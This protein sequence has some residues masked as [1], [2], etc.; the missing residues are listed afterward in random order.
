MRH[1]GGIIRRPAAPYSTHSRNNAMRFLILFLAAGLSLAAYPVAAQTAGTLSGTITDTAGAPVPGA[2]IVLMGTNRGALSKPDGSYLMVRVPPGT[3]QVRVTGIAMEEAR[4]EVTIAADSTA[5]L[6]FTLQPRK[7]GS[8][9]VTVTSG[10]PPEP[11]RRPDLRREDVGT[12]TGPCGIYGIPA[13]F[14]ADS[15]AKGEIAGRVIDERGNG[16]ADAQIEVIGQNP[17]AVTRATGNFV[18]KGVPAGTR[19]LIVAA[20][21][22]ETQE[23]R[24]TVIA[25][26]RTSLEVRLVDDGMTCRSQPLP[27]L[28]PIDP[29]TTGTISILSRQD[30]TGY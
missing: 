11:L 28:P 26:E 23:V 29:D 1:R 3:Y 21:G 9:T 10:L 16:I 15:G 8:D 22:M 17:A 12:R 4:K 18:L 19:T 20:F 30:M 25:N 24:V 27:S 2:R 6:D 14:I 5:A 13:H 7:D